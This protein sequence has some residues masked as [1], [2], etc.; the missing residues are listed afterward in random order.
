[1]AVAETPTT[2]RRIDL[3]EADLE[4]KVGD[5]AHR[6]RK[7][8]VANYYED[9]QSWGGIDVI[10][11][12]DEFLILGIDGEWRKPIPREGQAIEQ[13]VA[14]FDKALENALSDL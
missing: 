7:A 4:L 5:Y 14:L 10:P 6:L 9:T 8:S 11:S 13:L 1:M 3:S 12:E 2:D